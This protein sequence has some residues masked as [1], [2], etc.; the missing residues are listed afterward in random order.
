MLEGQLRRL[1]VET[2]ILRYW[3]DSFEIQL[4]CQVEYMDNRT[5]IVIVSREA[6]VLKIELINIYETL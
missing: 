3:N 6:E 1:V 2:I 5:Q 4:E